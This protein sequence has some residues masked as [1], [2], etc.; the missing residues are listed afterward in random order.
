MDDCREQIRVER[1]VVRVR[2]VIAS[3]S[4]L[5]GFSMRIGISVLTHSGQNIWENGI[6]QNVVFLARLLRELPDVENVVLLNCGDQDALPPQVDQETPGFA[7]M[8]PEDAT[9]HIDIAI[10]MGGAFDV[11]WLDYIRA[12]GK[13]AIWYCAGNP[14]AALVEPPVFGVSSYAGRIGRHDE[15]WMLPEYF[16]FAPMMRTLHRCPVHRVPYIW[17]PRFID[18]RAAEVSA[19]GLSFG[20]REGPRTLPP[21][22]LRVAVFEPNISVVK[23]SSI[24][25]LACDEAYRQEPGAVRSL[26]VLNTLHMVNHT[27]MLY[28][29]NALDL[30]RDHKTVF[31]GRH[32]FAGYM[33][34]H[35]DAVVSHQWANDQNYSYLDALHGDYPLIHNSPWLRGVGYYY[36]DFDA[37]AGAAQLLEAT[38]SHHEHLPDYRRSARALIDSLDP[39]HAANLRDYALRLQSVCATE[40]LPA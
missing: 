30:V 38:R 1:R 14:Y 33:A 27:T 32:D 7:L 24:S 36:A 40:E 23:T 5:L 35:A 20:W 16:Q 26:A 17:S 34:E 4:N 37:A 6:G 8:R 31:L 9:E 18:K 29:A 13:K 10:E 12:R 11:R 22:G 25:M 39:L 28:F 19:A 3:S 2:S 15:I 21:R